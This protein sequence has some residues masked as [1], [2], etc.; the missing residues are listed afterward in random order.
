M[1]HLFYIVLGLM[2]SAR[3]SAQTTAVIPD[4]AFRSFLVDHYPALM[5]VNEELIIANAASVTGTLY[6]GDERISN[7][8]GIQYFVNIDVLECQKNNLST[9]PDISALTKLTTLYCAENQL[10]SVPPLNNL[11]SLQTL[12]LAQNK[13]TTLPDVTALANLT[14]LVVYRNQL[15]SIPDLT[16]LSKLEKLYCFENNIASMGKLPASLKELWLGNNLMTYIPDISLATGLTS[17][18]AYTNHLQIVPDLTPYAVLTDLNLGT[19]QLTTVPTGLPSLSQLT[20]LTLDNN[21]LT[22]LPDLSGLTALA[23]CNLSSNSFTF[24]DLLPS[25]ANPNIA[26]WTICP[27][28]SLPAPA[29]IRITEGQPLTLTLAAD[30]GIPGL[31]FSWYCNGAQVAQTNQPVLT[32]P[33]ASKSHTGNWYC[34]VSSSAPGLSACTL[35]SH[36][37][38]IVVRPDF[39]M[40]KELTIT[41]NGDGK[42]DEWLFEESGALKVYNASGIL[43]DQ[44]SAPCYWNGTTGSGK[45]LGT[46]YY[47][48]T[49]EDTT[50][51]ITIIR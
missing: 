51:Q 4:T 3:L 29:N 20:L 12:V 9:L 33:A 44:Q 21:L 22:S 1:R 38:T 35:A 40:D 36:I 18:R 37:F 50:Y 8:E 30:D 14:D 47:I 10:T 48:I 25:S 39:T 45:I 15:T 23:T 26:S 11:V 49:I 31:T 5:D 16:V 2:L 46:G 7:L 41:P 42:N 43:V 32:I 28:D 34:K 27:Q 6:C 17:L 19:N 13:L 24:E